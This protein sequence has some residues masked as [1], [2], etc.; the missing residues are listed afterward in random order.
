[1][2]QLYAY[3][4]GKGD[5]IRIRFAETHNI[6]IDSGVIRFGS[7]FNQLCR[8]IISSGQTLD[9][10]ILTH[11]DEDHIGGFL[12]NLRL[13]SYQCPFSEVWMKHWSIS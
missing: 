1:M 8:E 2:L 4:A 11:V 10:L 3:N 13:N 7:K 5:C 6:I 12:A 9:T